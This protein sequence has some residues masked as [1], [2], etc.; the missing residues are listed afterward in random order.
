[1]PVT[2]ST[3][4]TL[5]AGMLFRLRQF[6]TTLGLETPRASA[7]FVA[8]PSCSMISETEGAA[9]FMPREYHAA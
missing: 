6:S 5:S 9:D 1:M 3:A 7:A 4:I 8:P 2:P